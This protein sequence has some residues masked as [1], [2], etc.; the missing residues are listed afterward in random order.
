MKCVY[1]YLPMLNCV[2]VPDVMYSLMISIALF[3]FETRMINIK[4]CIG[5]ADVTLM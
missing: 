2:G 1:D 4:N 3:E 5:D